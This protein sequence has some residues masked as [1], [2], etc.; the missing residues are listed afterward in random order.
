MNEHVFILT[1]LV[2]GLVLF[3]TCAGPLALA[4]KRG[5]E[6]LRHWY[7]AAV[8]LSLACIVFELLFPMP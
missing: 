4:P 2:S 5:N 8:L 6:H 7:I 3:I 1:L